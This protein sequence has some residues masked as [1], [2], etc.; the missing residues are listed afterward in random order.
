MLKTLCCLLC[1]KSA[2]LSSVVSFS[3][4]GSCSYDNKTMHMKNVSGETVRTL[5]ALGFVASFI[6]ARNNG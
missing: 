3:W 2:S 1:F 5:Q 6:R 4:G